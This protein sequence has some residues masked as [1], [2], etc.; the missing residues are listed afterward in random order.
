MS[1]REYFSVIWHATV[2]ITVYFGMLYL[3]VGMV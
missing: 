3:P 1:K 2:V